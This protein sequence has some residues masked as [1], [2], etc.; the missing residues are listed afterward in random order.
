MLTNYM[1]TGVRINYLLPIF[2]Q[3]EKGVDEEICSESTACGLFW[4]LRL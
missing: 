2:S 4:F 1:V 3:Q